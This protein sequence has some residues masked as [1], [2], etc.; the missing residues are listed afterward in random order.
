MT[1]PTGALY[2]TQEKAWMSESLML[3]W[4]EKILKPYGVTAPAGI[5]PLLF[6]DSYGVH[7]MGSVNRAINELGCKVIIIPP[8]CTGLTQPVDVG[9]NKPFKN[10][11]RDKY[12]NWMVMGSQDLT[13]P[14]RRVNVAQWIV[15]S[16]QEMDPTILRNAWK[17]HDLEYFPHVSTPPVC[18]EV[19]QV[20][21]WPET[22]ITPETIMMEPLMA[23]LPPLPEMVEEYVTDVS[24]VE[25]MEVSDENDNL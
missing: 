5:I 24:S 9:Y 3:F 12:E 22:T 16:E 19:E 6:L 15:E 10:L 23:A 20:L 8:G 4:I 25:K 21:T 13:V 17:R 1:Y 2:A 11:V 7:K 14:P 18:T